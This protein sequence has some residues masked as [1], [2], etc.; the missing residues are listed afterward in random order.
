[1]AQ[2]SYSSDLSRAYAGMIADGG[3][4]DVI[5]GINSTGSDIPFGVFVVMDSAAGEAKLPAASGDIGNKTLGVSAQ[6]T[7]QEPNDG[8]GHAD[9]AVFPVVNKG[10]VWCLA[11]ETLAQGDAVYVR[12]T[13]NGGNTLMG[14]IR[15][16]SDSSNAGL[17]SRAKVLDYVLVGSD[18]LALI[19]LS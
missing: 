14:R 13:A 11:E 10:R 19:E 18:K 9:G 4:K 15:N 8:N 12:H 5:S 16:D 7:A 3:F 6:V 1:M 17:L 2:L